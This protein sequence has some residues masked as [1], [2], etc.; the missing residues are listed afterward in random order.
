MTG[1][2]KKMGFIVAS[3]TIL[4]VGLCGSLYGNKFADASGILPPNNP[5][6]NIS[7]NPNYNNVCVQNGQP[8]NSQ[9]CYLSALAAI[10]NAILME[11]ATPVDM[12]SNYM[13][14]SYTQQLF[15]I[16]NEE[17]VARGLTPITG[18]TSALDTAAQTAAVDSTDPIIPSGYS[19]T[20]YGSNWAGGMQSVLAA[21]Y[22][23]M[24]EDGPGSA[25]LD[26]TSTNT[27]GCW[28]HRDN[29]LGSYD[30]NPCS[31]GDG[32]TTS[33]QPIGGTIYA[34][35]YAEIF[36]GDT[37]GVQLSY[38][39][40]WAQVLAN[41]TPA[42]AI[43]S[44]SSS[45][46]QS[47]QQLTV[48]G[49][50][51]TNV[52]ELVIGSTVVSSFNSVSSTQLSF[53]VPQ[54]SQGVYGVQVLT[55]GGISLVT[56]NSQIFVGQPPAAPTSVVAAAGNSQ[57][58]VTWIAPLN[59]SQLTGYTINVY[60]GG[61]LITSDSIAGT[62]PNNYVTINSLTNGTSYYFTVQATDNFGTSLPSTDS[63]TV[64]P[65]TSGLPVIASLTPPS[66]PISG[67]TSV[68]ILGTN[69]TSGSSVSF[70]TQPATSVS[71]VSSTEIIAVSPS[72]SNASTVNVYVTNSTGTSVSS[73]TDQFEYLEGYP[74]FALTPVRIMDT[75]S[76]SG[77]Q[78]Q[79]QTMQP[80]QTDS[81]TVTGTFGTQ[82]VPT[83]ATAVVVSLTVTNTQ[84]TG[85]FL[86]VY[87]A[88]TSEPNVSNINWNSNQSKAAL[89][90]VQIGQNGQIE[91]TD[92]PVGST[93]VI[94]DLMGYYVSYST[95]SDQ[96]AFIALPPNRLIDTRVNSGYEGSSSTLLQN[97]T[98]N[99][100][101]TG[102]GNVPSSGVAA[103]VLEITA[104]NTN[105][106]GGYF[107][108]WPTG[109]PMPQTSVLNWDS[110]QT[111]ANRIVVGVS[112]NSSSYGQ[113]SVYNAFGTADLVVDVEGY[114]TGPQD[115]PGTVQGN[116]GFFN[117]IVPFRICDTRLTSGNQCANKSLSSTGEN[118]SVTVAGQSSGTSSIPS[119][120]STTPPVAV[121][122]NITVAST[123]QWSFLTA[124]PPGQTEPNTSDLNW[125][126]AI[127]ATSNMDE[128]ILGSGQINIANA[129]GST[130]VIVDVFGWYS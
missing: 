34:P 77:Y 125:S 97:T 44:L 124:W 20:S 129:F 74:Y 67:N 95:S 78:Y 94:V 53:T 32:F 118:L 127:W 21:D 40:T 100:Q 113:I 106:N 60:S 87:P 62:P 50:N 128:V 92:G 55:P 130:Q 84:S 86:T 4:I 22:M 15:V 12:P 70:G 9:G 28:G 17:R 29:I 38:Q 99:F 103:V 112:Q 19:F 24:Y 36:V 126:Q 83:N 27:T 91:I 123:T 107:T 1:K 80:N 68:E 69:F 16:A 105:S 119:L 52:M 111:V 102:I 39:F 120:T 33:P 7:P 93:D 13:S 37:S 51:L 65:S 108:V 2:L 98:T 10:D 18:T 56:A 109:A 30:C 6:S 25:N 3:L 88:G 31:Q 122:A 96:G 104:T 89:V 73:G 41:L 66:G 90:V 63:N 5:A 101:I 117:P 75:R 47:G 64:T 46:I 54:L 23:W 61:N 14:L 85:G 49:S 76:N 114:F 11:G 48:Y 72:T 121:V 43:S 110:G 71:V 57:A 8:D 45:F 35:S 82:I 26:C 58:T 116:E 59:Y 42:P 81:L 115:I 79:G